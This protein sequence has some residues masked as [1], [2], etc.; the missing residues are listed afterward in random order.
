M[1]FILCGVVSARIAR[2]LDA[3]RSGVIRMSAI[4]DQELPQIQ[5]LMSQYADRLM[6]FADATL[7]YLA[8]TSTLRSTTMTLKVTDSRA[9]RS[10][11]CSR[12]RP[13]DSHKS[14]LKSRPDRD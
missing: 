3:L 7:V 1:P 11:R 12:C 9:E 6:D 2:D 14:R 13:D 5:A 10:L 8:I 4:A